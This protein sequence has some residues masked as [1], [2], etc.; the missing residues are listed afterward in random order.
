MQS[1]NKIGRTF[2]KL[3]VEQ[4]FSK[5][6]TSEIFNLVTDWYNFL[7]KQVFKKFAANFKKILTRF[8]RFL[9]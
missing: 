7:K 6:F 9:N 5:S 8:N 4:I 2:K 1:F 3:S